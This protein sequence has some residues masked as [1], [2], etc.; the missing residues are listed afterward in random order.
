MGSATSVGF[1]EETKLCVSSGGVTFTAPLR[2]GNSQQIAHY[3]VT[4]G[5]ADVTETRH[6]EKE[7][8]AIM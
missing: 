2:S 4:F 5:P 3:V 1:R 7:T 6:T 8:N